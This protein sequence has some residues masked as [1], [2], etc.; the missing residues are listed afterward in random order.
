MEAV[1]MRP[2]ML[3]RSGNIRGD[4]VDILAADAPIDLV[5]PDRRTAPGRQ[6]KLRHDEEATQRR[7]HTVEDRTTARLLEESQLRLDEVKR[8]FRMRANRAIGIG[9]DG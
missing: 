4:D 2:I 5:E 7:C 3:R 9:L 1:G 8:L 6:E